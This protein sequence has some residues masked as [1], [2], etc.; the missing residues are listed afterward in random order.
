METVR[1][2][3]IPSIERL[4]QTPAAQALET[5]YGREAL[6]D[7]LRAET[8]ALRQQL[9]AAPAESAESAEDTNS[10]GEARGIADRLIDAAGLR[11]ARMLG[12]QLQPVINA[13]GVIIHTNLG[14]APLG[15][16]ALA[17]MIAIG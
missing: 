9:T 5:R 2:R 6:I 4:R 14:R 12:S 17:R 3:L 13:T 16:T 15:E 10:E 1:A 11:L 8:S 7:A